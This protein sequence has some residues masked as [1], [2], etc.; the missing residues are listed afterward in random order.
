V[1]KV[2]SSARS[3]TD[4][5]RFIY[6]DVANEPNGM[7]LSV[8][9]ALSRRGLDPW[10]EAHRLAQR[11]PFAAADRLAQILRP[12]PAIQASR[13]DAKAISERL[14]ALLPVQDGVAEGLSA[15]TPVPIGRG[16]TIAIIAAMFG[17]L[18]MALLIPK[19]ADPVAPTSWIADALKA[20]AKLRLAPGQSSS[21]IPPGRTGGAGASPAMGLTEAA[22]SL[23][24]TA[25]ELASKRLTFTEVIIHLNQEL[26]LASALP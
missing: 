10:Y 14:V 20:S 7:E 9:S 4:F 15:A 23:R 5:A 18:L 21:S 16:L 11:P 26:E 6:A 12:L 13:L 17:G 19:Q 3:N 8:L 25:G 2:G 22:I 1:S 24:Q